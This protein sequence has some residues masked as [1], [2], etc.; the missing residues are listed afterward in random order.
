MAP[1]YHP[2]SNRT[3]TTPYARQRTPCNHP[4]SL[5]CSP[6]FHLHPVPLPTNNRTT[7]TYWRPCSHI[8]APPALYNTACS[9]PYTVHAWKAQPYSRG[10]YAIEAM[11]CNSVLPYAPCGHGPP[12]APQQHQLN[13]RHAHQH[14]TPGGSGTQRHPSPATTLLC[15][16][17][18]SLAER[19][20]YTW[21]PSLDRPPT[22]STP[23]LTASSRPAL[24]S[25]AYGPRLVRAGLL[26]LLPLP[27]RQRAPHVH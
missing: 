26:K 18:H 12:P 21:A 20:G 2:S 7:P 15:W 16:G 3:A 23:A 17:T 6:A 8:H 1:P 27:P 13:N 10:C 24:H 19:S 4:H 11:E 9:Y 25:P 5:Q 22:P 14:V